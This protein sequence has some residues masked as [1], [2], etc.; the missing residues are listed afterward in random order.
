MVFRCYHF[1]ILIHVLGCCAHQSCMW[2][3][4]VSL[5][6][7]HCYMKLIAWHFRYQSFPHLISVIK[8]LTH[9]LG[10]ICCLPP[11]NLCKEMC[12]LFFKN[13]FL[14]VFKL[15]GEYSK[16]KNDF[17]HIIKRTAFPLLD[18][19]G[20]LPQTCTVI[21]LPWKLALTRLN[22]LNVRCCKS[23]GVEMQVLC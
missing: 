23:V 17:I 9:A 3:D 5:C 15:F 2:K 12:F 20:G 14:N 19:C 22:N 18:R 13:D 1:Q 8:I 11:Y 7:V 16:L 10:A 21:L 6:S 4:M